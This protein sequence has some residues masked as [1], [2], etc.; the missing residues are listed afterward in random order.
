MSRKY[1]DYKVQFNTLG[2]QF[3]FNQLNDAIEC[4][5][6]RITKPI[7]A[8]IKSR[9]ADRGFTNRFHIEEAWT[10]LAG[11][12]PYHPIKDYFEG[13]QWNGQDT[14]GQ[15]MDAWDF[16]HR[17]FSRKAFWKFFIGSVAKVFDYF[18]NFMLIVNG[19]QGCGKSHSMDWV[20]SPLSRYFIEGPLSPDSKDTQL[21]VT[22]TF[23]WEVGE[24]QSTTRKADQEALKNIITQKHMTVRRPYSK[25][26]LEKPITASFVGTINENGSGFLTDTTGSRRFVVVQTHKIDWGFTKLDPNQIWAQ[27]YA[28]YLAGESGK[29]DS[30]IVKQQYQINQSY[31]VESIAVQLLHKHYE[32]NPI[33]LVDEWIPVADI[34]TNLELQGLKIPQKLSQMEIA[35]ELARLGCQK[36]TS[37]ATTGNGRLTCYNGIQVKQPA[38]I[39]IP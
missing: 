30:Q 26:D 22:S 8:T 13:L 36:S 29:L 38:R 25:Y 21:R 6:E 20:S 17:A 16:E 23:L 5:G 19:P 32:V 27:V 9:M 31:Q 2:Y 4:N 39:N 3:R 24:F 35:G 10:R 14:F 34:V 33:T 37:N 12:N 28:A 18:Q 7:E 1:N 11:A 15:F